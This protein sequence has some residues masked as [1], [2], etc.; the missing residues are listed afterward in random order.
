MN[1]Y[2]LWGWRKIMRQSKWLPLAA[3]C[4]ALVTAPAFAATDVANEDTVLSPNGDTK[5]YSFTL[6]G[7]TP[8]H[9]DATGVKNTDKGFDL[10]VCPADDFQSCSGQVRGGQCRAV[11]E[12]DG[13]AVKSFTHTGTLPAGRWTLFVKN[14][15]NNFFRATIHVHATVGQ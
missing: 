1:L 3:V 9:V 11:G 7:P 15:Y 10:R 12:F 13:I 2:P 6:Q 4:G 5:F 8:F 14:T